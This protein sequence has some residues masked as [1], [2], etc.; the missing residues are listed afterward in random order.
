MSESSSLITCTN[1]D[2]PGACNRRVAARVWCHL[3][4]I[5]ANG[6][7]SAWHKQSADRLPMRFSST[8]PELTRL[9][10]DSRRSAG[11]HHRT[12][13]SAPA[14]QTS[15]VA[16]SSSAGAP[17]RVTAGSHT[18]I[19][20]WRRASLLRVHLLIMSHR[21][22]R[23]ALVSPLRARYLGR[24]GLARLRKFGRATGQVL[25]GSHSVPLSPSAAC[26][27]H[28]CCTH[29]PVPL[30]TLCC[31]QHSRCTHH[32][33]PLCT[34][35]CLQHSRCTHHPVPLR[36]LCCL[37]HS[38]CTHLSVP[39]RTLCC[40]QH[41][42]CTHLSVPLSPFAA[43]MPATHLLHTPLSPPRHPLLLATPLMH[44]S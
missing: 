40:L 24:E 39:L 31:L 1:S 22:D 6:C 30:C 43:C 11:A 7:S 21:L 42:R 20:P 28:T 15:R 35:C 13:T 3:A 8:T 25:Q 38:R 29:H 2:G 37:Q 17:H 10:V 5:Q 44:T 32:P 23:V 26:L 12:R 33:V 18:A 4:R 19:L 41:L 36:T 27:Q 16:R 34:L 9:H 14:L